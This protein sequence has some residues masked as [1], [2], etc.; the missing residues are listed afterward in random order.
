MTQIFILNKT[1]FV[2]TYRLSDRYLLD[3]QT[4]LKSYI[5]IIILHGILASITI[6]NEMYYVL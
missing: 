2:K 4:I 6:Q 5:F 3:A 1:S